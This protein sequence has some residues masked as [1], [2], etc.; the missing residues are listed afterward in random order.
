MNRSVLT[1]GLM[2]LKK[3]DTRTNKAKP[4]HL[5]FPLLKIEN[6]DCSFNKMMGIYRLQKPFECHCRHDT[7]MSL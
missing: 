1:G 6:I 3:I 5:F 7:F 4:N 2:T